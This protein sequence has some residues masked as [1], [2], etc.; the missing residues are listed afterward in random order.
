MDQFR[1][2]HKTSFEWKL[3]RRNNTFLTMD[4]DH[5]DRRDTIIR[6]GLAKVSR[7]SMKDVSII[8][9]TSHFIGIQSIQ[10][11]LVLAV[12]FILQTGASDSR[13]KSTCK[14]AS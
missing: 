14:T 4:A 2:Y 6:M 3:H 1:D 10:H 12:R 11:N 5:R 7:F 8:G 13:D 9:K